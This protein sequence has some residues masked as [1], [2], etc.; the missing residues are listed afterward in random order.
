MV[1]KMT[2]YIIF[3]L[4]VMVP[5]VKNNWKMIQLY[6]E[7]NPA[8][9]GFNG[10]IKIQ[11]RSDFLYSVWCDWL[12]VD[13]GYFAGLSLVGISLFS[14]HLLGQAGASIHGTHVQ[15]LVYNISTSMMKKTC[16]QTLLMSELLQRYNFFDFLYLI[17]IYLFIKIQWTNIKS[18]FFYISTLVTVFQLL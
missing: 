3:L 6:L 4:F 5:S 13:A 18:E 10:W 9:S 15:R 17:Y 7:I 1:G 2:Y 12:V 8:L 14:K 16:C 11:S